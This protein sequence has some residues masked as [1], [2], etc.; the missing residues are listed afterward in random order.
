[1]ERAKGFE[2]SAKKWEVV[3]GKPVKKLTS[4]GYTQIREQVT[5]E[6]ERL[7]VYATWPKLPPRIQKSI[8]LLVD[9]S[10]KEEDEP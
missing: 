1:M 7:R 9:A 6:A 3:N 2:P 10:V 4:E 8:V 5:E